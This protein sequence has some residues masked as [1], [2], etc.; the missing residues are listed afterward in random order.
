MGRSLVEDD[1]LKDFYRILKA[2]SAAQAAAKEKDPEKAEKH[3]RAE[4]RLKSKLQKEELSELFDLFEQ[5]MT[6]VQDKPQLQDA[7][8]S[9]GTP[10]QGNYEHPVTQQ[11]KEVDALIKQ[12][13][14]PIEAHKAVHGELDIGEIESKKKLAGTLGRIQQQGSTNG[15][16]YDKD[17]EFVSILAADAEIE[18]DLD[19]VTRNDLRTP[20]EKQVPDYQQQPGQQVAEEKSCGKGEYYCNDDQKCKPIPEGHAVDDSGFLYKKEEIDYHEF[21]V[22]YLQKFGRA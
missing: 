9:M 14:S 2:S 15:I 6:M 5:E 22:A 8:P 7:E 1:D 12:G 11:R 20:Y 13:E 16:K 19:Q 3:Y 10:Q 21:D 4:R 18:K 17:G